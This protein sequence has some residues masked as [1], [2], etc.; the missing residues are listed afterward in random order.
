VVVP[1]L[2]LILW[3]RG[4]YAQEILL[5]GPDELARV[6]SAC[7]YGVV[8][9]VAASFLNGDGPMVSRGWLLI[10]W[11]LAVLLQGAGRCLLRR[12]A[13]VQRRQGRFVRRVL[14]AGA[15]DQ[16]VALAQQIHGPAAKGIEVLGFLDDYLPIGTRVADD[17]DA[18][19]LQVL[20]H[21]RGAAS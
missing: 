4:A 2:L 8:L 19:H 6:T 18:E 3:L 20:G 1:G 17:D 13:A 5:G 12:I 9:V 7:T 11:A 16:G 10:F 21:P 15:S 14:I